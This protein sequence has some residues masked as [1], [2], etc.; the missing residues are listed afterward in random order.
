MAPA[1][2]DRSNADPQSFA[3]LADYLQTE[4]DERS[5]VM[6]RQLHDDLS[7][8]LIAAVMDIAWLTRHTTAAGAE[9]AMRLHRIDGRLTNAIEWTRRLID[10]LQPALIE[11]VGLFVAV[12]AHFE[13]A[14]LRYGIRYSETVIGVIPEIDA[15]TA[16]AV[17]RIAQDF[18]RW[19]REDAGASEVLACYEGEAGR[20]TMHFV[21]RG[22]AAAALPQ[23]GLIAPRL[24]A[25]ALRLRKL[26]GTLNSEATDGSLTIRVQIPVDAPH[27]DR[28]L[29]A[30]QHDKTGSAP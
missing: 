16:M 20:L 29:S 9:V 8:S 11:S 4:A 26:S 1:P 2:F 3:A 5:R 24:A 25:I 28:R 13:R 27:A 14:C 17:F 23:Q 15:A 21:V 19:M 18:L 7:G 12:G 6:A 30:S 10:E 22:M